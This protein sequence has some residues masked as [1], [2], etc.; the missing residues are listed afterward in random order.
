[1]KREC[2]L[3]G[4]IQDDYWMRSYNIG[5]RTIWVCWDCF[6]NAE[7]E[8]TMSDMTRGRQLHKIFISKKVRK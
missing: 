3:C 1:M 7:R 6:L 4:L 2:D 5:S 8:A